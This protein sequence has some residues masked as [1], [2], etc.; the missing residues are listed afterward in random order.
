MIQGDSKIYFIMGVSGCGKSTIGNL[1]SDELKI[2][3]YDGD[4]YHSETN[5]KKMASGQPLTDDDRMDWLLSLNEIALNRR[6]KGAIIGCSA[7]KESY[8]KILENNLENDVN[9]IYLSGSF[10]EVMSRLNQRKG[11]FMPAALLKSQ[12][13]TLEIP[14]NAIKVSINQSAGQIVKRILELIESQ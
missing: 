9:W 14:G 11:H 7:L 13:E 10:D 12:F 8:R 3:F 5:V 4:D 1:L 2:P 6:E